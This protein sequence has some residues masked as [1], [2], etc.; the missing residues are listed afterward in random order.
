MAENNLDIGQVIIENTKR[1]NVLSEEYDP[2]I[3][4]GSPIE[5]VRLNLDNNKYFNIP[6]DMYEENELFRKIGDKSLIKIAKSA[7]TDVNNVLKYLIRE[8]CKYDFEFWC[9]TCVTILT[10]ESGLQRFILNRPQRRVLKELERL[11]LSNKPIKVILL[12]ARQWG[13]STLSQ[14]YIAWLQLFHKPEWNALVVADVKEKAQHIRAMYERMAKYHPKGIIPDMEELVLKSYQGTQNFKTIGDRNAIIGVTS[15]ETPHSPRA[16]T[17]HF[18]HLSEVGLWKST[19]FVNA[20]EL[21]SALEG[22]LVDAPYT[23][24]IKESTAW[25]VGSYFH[26]EWQRAVKGDSNYTPV[27]VSWFE[28]GKQYNQPVKNIKEFVE[29]WNDYEKY[30]WN[31]GA[32]LEHI[33]WY[34]NKLRDYENHWKLMSEFPS[35]PEEAFQSTGSRVFRSEIV[36]SARKNCMPPIAVGSLIADGDKYEKALS[37]MRFQEHKGGNLSI[38]TFPNL[39]GI[40]KRGVIYVNRYCAFADVGGKSDKSDFSTLTVL[41]RILTLYGGVPYV[42]AEYHG[43]IDPDLFAWLCARISKWYENA[44]LAVEVNTLINQSAIKG[45]YEGEHGITVLDEIKEYYDNLFYRIQPGTIQEKWSGVLGFHTNKHT[46]NLI[47][48]ALNAALRDGEF[49]ERSLAACDEYDSYEYKPD[50]SMG[51]VSGAHDDRVISRAG[52][53]WLSGQ[54]PPVMEIKR[55]TKFAIAKKGNFAEYF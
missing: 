27:F 53:I 36:L 46:K 25:G 22:S 3:G 28:D 52:A 40:E 49:E 1:W 20:E 30:L 21:I 41:D 33:Q 45:S 24:C 19:A 34:R 9:A 35:T 7:K 11:R 39:L 10:K 51:A 43:H 29:S 18:L 13:G 4:I 44:L 26:R 15:V 47:I 17:L 12:K 55:S 16:F 50:G 32:T 38:W 31:I 5:R 23:L 42:C 37:N 8:R 48:D 6:V 2:V 14:I 54:M